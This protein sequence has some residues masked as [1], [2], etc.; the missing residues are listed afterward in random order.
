MIEFAC[1]DIVATP[2]SKDL[3]SFYPN[4]G[5]VNYIIFYPNP[6]KIR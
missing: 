2:L 1:A 6:Y 3:W 5:L 4:A